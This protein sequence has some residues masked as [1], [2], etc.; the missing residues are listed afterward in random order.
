MGKYRGSLSRKRADVVRDALQGA[1]E[2]R[3]GAWH[4]RLPSSP[5]NICSP[6]GIISTWVHI[7]MLKNQG[8][9]L[10][11]ITGPSNTFSGILALSPS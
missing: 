5:G 6:K 4:L 3:R 8:F 9:E 10:S 11:K 2:L 1:Y 7:N